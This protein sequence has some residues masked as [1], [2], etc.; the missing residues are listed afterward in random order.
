MVKG[1]IIATIGL[2]G[3]DLGVNHGEI[4]HSIAVHGAA[5]CHSLG[6]WVYA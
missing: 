4:L 3:Y 2:L 6:T 5:F 1:I